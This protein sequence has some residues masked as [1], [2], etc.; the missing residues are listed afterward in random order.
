MTINFTR[1]GVSK[2]EWLE[3]ALDYLA[4][5]S[6]HSLNIE[7][8]A[9]K[10]GIAKSGFYW[11]FGNRDE[12]LREMLS[13]WNHEINEVVTTN[14]ELLEM[15][16]IERLRRTAETIFDYDLARWEMAFR[17]W[18]LEDRS[19]AQVVRKANRMRMNF[20]V[21][22]FNELGFE[23]EEAEMRSMTLITSMAWDMHTFGY[24]SR[25]K[26]RAMI[27]QRIKLLTSKTA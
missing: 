21:R 1:R 3:A 17:Q 15:K 13:Y 2:A 16:P 20:L 10:L 11:H 23:R 9:S 12:L 27:G 18:A 7:Y 19:A 24:I 22:T 4:T 8:L 26:R 6:V 25:K 5:G 14:P